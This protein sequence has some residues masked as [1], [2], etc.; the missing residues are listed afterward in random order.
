MH[1]NFAFFIGA[2]LL[3]PLAL[4]AK[5]ADYHHTKGGGQEDLSCYEA[6]FQTLSDLENLVNESG[7]TY[8]SLLAAGHPLAKAIYAEND[9]AKSLL[10]MHT[11]EEGPLLDIPGF[12]WGFCCSFFGIILVLVSIDDNQVR[13]KETAQAAAGCAVGCLIWVGLYVWAIIASSY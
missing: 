13:K 1:K 4:A 11:P 12:L 2:M 9:L 6:E 7:D 3:F 8:S 10:G 5:A